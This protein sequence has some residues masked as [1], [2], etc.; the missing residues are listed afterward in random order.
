MPSGMVVVCLTIRKKERLR[1]LNTS[2]IN[3]EAVSGAAIY[4]QE[5]GVINLDLSDRVEQHCQLR[6]VVVSLIRQMPRSTLSELPLMETLLCMEPVSITMKISLNLNLIN[7]TVSNNVATNDGG[8]CLITRWFLA[9]I[10]NATISGNE[11]GN[12]GAG[13]FNSDEGTLEIT[14][15]TIFNNAATTGGGIFNDT[16]GLSAWS[17]PSSPEIQRQCSVLMSRGYSTLKEIT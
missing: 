2:F 7:S 17:I 12:N 1:S 4:N 16:D 10:V 13:I 14:N 6:M 15:V 3:N 5:L 11:A 8:G 9:S